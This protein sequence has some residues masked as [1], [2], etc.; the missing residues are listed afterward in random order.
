[1]VVGIISTWRRRWRG[2]KRGVA[3]GI[4]VFGSPGFGDP[5]RLQELLSEN[6]EVMRWATE[7]SLALSDEPDGLSTL[8]G[9]MNDWAVDPEIG[10]RLGNEVGLFLG[11]I[12]VKSVEGSH[13]SVWPNGHPVVRLVSG[14]D[15][16]VTALVDQRLKGKGMSLADV[17][18]KAL[19]D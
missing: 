6:N 15:V 3:R 13:W 2:P 5:D 4:T 8:E 9:V 19:S 11:N 1:M 10:H 7:R 14:R 12:I 16:D 18:L 17:Y